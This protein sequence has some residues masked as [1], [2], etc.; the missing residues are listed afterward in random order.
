ML[1]Y[2]IMRPEGILVLKP[3]APLSKED[4]SGL[5]PVVD[6]YLSDHPRLHGV[7]V[8]S[9]AFPGWED[10]E[11]FLAHMHFA[12]EHHK[13]V[14]RVA[15]VTDSPIAGLAESLAS[16]FSSAKVKS[17]PFV[18]DATALDWLEQA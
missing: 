5:R 17:F 11:G 18:A 6:A 4:F 13:Q 2:S 15:I 16:H 1:D 8:Q 14:E 7:L 3:H 10:F 12:S 9:K